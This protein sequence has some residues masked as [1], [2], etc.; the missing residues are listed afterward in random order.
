MYISMWKHFKEAIVRGMIVSLAGIC[1]LGLLACGSKAKKQ[2][3]AS[4][5]GVQEADVQQADS[6]KTDDKQLD[7]A[8]DSAAVS[9]HSK[10]MV[11]SSTKN[12][13]NSIKEAGSNP[14]EDGKKDNKNKKDSSQVNSNTVAQKAEE[15]TAGDGK[16]DNSTQE[17]VIG[18]TENASEKAKQI[19]AATA[20]E[21]S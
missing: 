6:Q 9:E 12:E 16:E 15:N 4:R 2:A 21:K 13:E 8:K 18:K 10:E 19:A 5:Q 1:I 3:D 14:S 17:M 11:G 7:P 20:Q